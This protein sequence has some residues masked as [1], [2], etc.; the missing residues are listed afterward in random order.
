MGKTER[1]KQPLPKWRRIL[2]GLVLMA[3][4]S[5]A[6]FML[7][8]YFIERQLGKEI[9]KIGQAGEPVTFADLQPVPVPGAI[10][11]DAA[12]YYV[13]VLSRIPPGD[14]ENLKRIHIFYHKNIV[15]L[16]SN[17]FP[18]DTR[19][20]VAQNLVG[21]KPMLEKL[22]KSADLPL[23]NFDIGIEQGM[24]V[25]QTRLGS[26]RA[27][28]LLLSLRTLES[29]LSGDG[30]TA[31]NS[32]ISS[33][34]MM[35]IFD[36]SPTMTV[37]TV[38]ILFVA[39]LCQDIH[40]LLLYSRP[41][42]NSLLKL[43]KVLSEIIGPDALERMF[44]A[45]RVYQIELGRNLIPRKISSRLLQEK[46]PDLPERLSL[47]GNRWGRL[48]LRQL[49]TAFL[50]DIAWLITSV[51]SPW[52]EPLDTIIARVTASKEKSNSLLTNSAT[53]ISLTAET[54]TFVRCT[55][56]AIAVERYRRTHDQL[57]GSLDDMVPN[58][59]DS[60]PLDPFTGN[61]LL[62]NYDKEGYV[63]YSAGNNRQDDGGLVI[64]KP[65]QPV[66]LDHGI[67]IQFGQP[68]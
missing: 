43:Q 32:I 7:V 50:R 47:P 26:V 8:G 14:V 28:V 36:F 10:G 51:R 65:D 40:I 25:C 54:V 5:L 20:K 18:G 60:V 12:V 42:D 3:M 22:D 46:V 63:V 66:R 52:P 27:A 13:E 4:V 16:P 64:R 29:I 61:K 48:R 33:L 15:S 37:Y 11:N 62:Y 9:V 1:E 21:L 17:Q 19:E 34:K 57:P 68:Q 38:R 59:I 39:Q 44:Y 23:S 6:A 58:Y 67:H 24:E 56:L 41:S 49:A 2:L 53:S 45:E 31:A 55:T 35:R 30:D